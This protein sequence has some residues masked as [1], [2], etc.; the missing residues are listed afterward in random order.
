MKENQKIP[1]VKSIATENANME[2]NVNII[3]L[4]NVLT[5]A[6]TEDR[7]AI[8]AMHV[9]IYTLYC[10]E[11]RSIMENVSIKNALMPI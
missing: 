9:D 5:T 3:T 8:K 11:T 7:V 10:A 2:I 4:K 1:S 6:D